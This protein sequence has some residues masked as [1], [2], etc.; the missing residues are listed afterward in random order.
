MEGFKWD[1]KYSIEIPEIDEQHKRL[2]DLI[3]KVFEVA[4]KK[5]DF[6]KV[7]EIFA[8]LEKYVVYHF[9]VEEKIMT[10]CKYPDLEA[11]KVEHKK[12]VAKVLEEKERAINSK[13]LSFELM[14]F[15]NNWLIH[16]I[17]K[18]DKEYAKFFIKQ[19]KGFFSKLF[20]MFK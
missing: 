9:G 7:E 6:S 3:A 18:S 11:H 20:S 17:Q 8:E 13:K 1:D 14:G 19:K 2:F 4:G 5:E 16:H 15:L 12:F 10:Q